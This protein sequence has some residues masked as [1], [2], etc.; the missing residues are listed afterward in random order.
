MK[1]KKSIK[2]IDNFLD[3]K[4]FKKLQTF[5][6]G[7]EFAWFY[8]KKKVDYIKNPFFRTEDA[9]RSPITPIKGYEADDTHQFTHSFFQKQMNWS[10]ASIN[11]APLLD[12]INPRV[13]IKV[14]GNL[15]SINSNPLVGGWHCDKDTDGKAWTD[16]TTAIFFINT[17]NGYTMFENGKKVP[18]VENTL[19]TF[20]NN[21][22]HTGVSQTD[23]KVKVTLNLNY[24][25]GP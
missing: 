15:S 21:I 17:N 3:K 11:I 12:K 22:L 25:G 13:W 1:K 2:V 4:V 20:P 5:L 23:T 9:G 8:N 18:S 6:L 14:K 10:N 7:D 19:V 16:T 24:L